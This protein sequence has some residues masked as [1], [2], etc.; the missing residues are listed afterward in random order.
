[1]GAPALKMIGALATALG[2][3]A[4]RAQALV[5]AV[6]KDDEDD[7]LV[8]EADEA[9]A[10][11]RDPELL[12]R[13]QKKVSDDRRVESLRVR[14]KEESAAGRHDSAISAL[15]R[16]VL[17]ATADSRPEIEGE[18]REEYESVGFG[19]ETESRLLREARDAKTTD[20]ARADKWAEIAHGR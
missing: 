2:D 7:R 20:V 9:L 19:P 11:H 8:A 6:E 14:A 18:L 13:F 4:T 15:E 12:A 10:T 3:D 5:M 17:A 1:V 16:A